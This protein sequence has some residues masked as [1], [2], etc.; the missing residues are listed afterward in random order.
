MRS[1]AVRRVGI[2]LLVIGLVMTA[3]SVYTGLVNLYVV[4]II[5]VLT[6]NSAFGTLPLLVIFAGIV[7]IIL[8]PAFG[9]NETGTIMRDDSSIRNGAE[10]KKMKFGGVVLIGPIPILFGSN[11]RMALIAAAIAISILALL[12]LLL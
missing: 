4:L 12:V 2:A 1:S 5:P 8:G 10:H 9:E 7:L 6:S 3:W 11:K